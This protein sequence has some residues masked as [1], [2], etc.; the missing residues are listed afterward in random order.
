MNSNK[1]SVWG[2]PNNYVRVYGG[3]RGLRN[4]TRRSKIFEV[5][6]KKSYKVGMNEN[7]AA[8]PEENREK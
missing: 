2:L 1:V 7:Y 4:L 5:S 3:R 6:Y 8:M